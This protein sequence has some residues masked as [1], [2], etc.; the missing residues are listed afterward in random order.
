VAQSRNRDILNAVHKGN[1]FLTRLEGEWWARFS[2]P[3][4]AMDETAP[5]MRTAGVTAVPYPAHM[6][7][8]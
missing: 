5:G 8:G 2:D 3:E 1:A 7:A 6:D 4:W